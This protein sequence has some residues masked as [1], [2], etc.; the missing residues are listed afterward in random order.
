MFLYC[1]VYTGISSVETDDEKSLVV[2]CFHQGELFFQGHRGGTANSCTGF[3]VICELH[4]Y[5]TAGIK[6]E[7]GLFQKVLTFNGDQ[8]RV[9]GAGSDDLDESLAFSSTVHGNGKS[10][11]IAFAEF[12]FLFFKDKSGVAGCFQRTG[13]GY[14]GYAGHVKYFCGRVGDLDTLQ[15][16][17]GVN[18]EF[19]VVISYQLMDER[20]VFFEVDGRHA[21]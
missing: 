5:E 3:G 19:S 17:G 2:E 12:T 14:S 21:F 9:S 7:V 16:L 8:F 6:D 4:G 10:K 20:F 15:F 13:F 11:V 1:P 18:V